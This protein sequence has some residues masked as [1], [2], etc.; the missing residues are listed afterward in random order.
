MEIHVLAPEVI[1]QIAA[2][3]VVER[4]AH[5]VKELVENSIDAGADEIEVQVEQGGRWVKVRD[6]GRGISRASL[7]LSLAR[8][9]TSKISNSS[10]LWGLS[11][12]GFRGEALASIAA[13]SRLTLITKMKDQKGH[14]LI[15]EFGKARD[16]EEVGADFGTTVIIED[17][18]SNVPA[19]LKFLKSDSAEITQIKNVLKAMALAYPNIN[20][21][22]RSNNKLI[23]FW[24]KTESLKERAEQILEKNPLYFGDAEVEG[25]RAQVCISAPN[26]TTG[27]SRQIWLFA[28]KR[29]VQDRSLQA[30]I[31]DG[32]RN[33]LMHGEFPY[34]VAWVNC[35]PEEID[36]NIHPTKSQVKFL[37][38]NN[39]FRAVNRAVR[40][41]LEKA[42]WVKET[43]G[44]TPTYRPE[45]ELRLEKST[46]SESLR[47]QDEAF[48]KTNYSKKDFAFT[49]NENMSV[50][51]TLKTYSPISKRQYKDDNELDRYLETEK[52][53][54]EEKVILTE[55]VAET[56]S[57]TKL[58]SRLD[59]LGQADLTYIV[60]QNEKALL[61]VDQHAAHERVAFETLMSAWK[62]GKLDIQNYLVPL[63]V[64]LENEKVEALISQKDDIEKLGVH[65]E[66]MGPESIAVNAAPTLLKEKALV[67]A[68]HL[69]ADEM[70]DRGGSFAL[71]KVIGD[72][73]ATLACHS[74]V[75]AG[76]ALSKDQMR[77][78][79]EQMDEFPLSSFCPHGRPVY[80]EYPFSKVEKDF[81]RIV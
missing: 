71:E 41:V 30:A 42:P 6:N 77:A 73:C 9:A 47:F 2:G 28:Q 61:L 63:V 37:K 46:N 72:I 79:L 51:E 67:Q 17:L 22:V 15:S 76:Q 60:A 53:Y 13:V 62:G 34:A 44:T 24:A 75:R 19:R 21:K 4:P 26:E 20:L 38:A 39:A 31:M 52:T 7:P 70:M 29:W 74:V 40:E 12:Y 3:E 45:N 27:N 64:D 69:L 65:I 78:L 35:D 80:V 57:G 16:V 11:S 81:G 32:Y 66:Q 58:W 68:L 23:Y 33:L 43:I 48:Q 5:L 50:M 59:I 54:N 1:D 8:H 55:N 18:F 14:Q 25:V 36:V 49:K 10:D 56:T